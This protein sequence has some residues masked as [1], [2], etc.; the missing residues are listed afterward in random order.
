M[1]N[2]PYSLNQPVEVPG[3]EGGIVVHGLTG[4]FDSLLYKKRTGGKEEERISIAPSTFSVGMFSWFPLFFPLREPMFLPAG[5]KM[6]VSIWRIKATRTYGM[7]GGWRWRIG[8]GGLWG[9]QT[10]ITSTG[11]AT[12]WGYE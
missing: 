2:P 3:G 1:C 10:S 4:T 7:S 9:N 5:G 8:W 12:R 11:G 6:A